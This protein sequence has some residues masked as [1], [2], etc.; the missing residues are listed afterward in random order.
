[1]KNINNFISA[2]M[3]NESVSDNDI[4]KV[5]DWIKK[6]DNRYLVEKSKDAIK[7]VYNQE[8][9]SS[10]TK[11]GKFYA[12][13]SIIIKQ[14]GDT[15]RISRPTNSGR[16]SYPSKKSKVKLTNIDDVIETLDMFAGWFDYLSVNGHE[17]DWHLPHS[18]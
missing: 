3:I 8:H 13:S 17:N 11:Y 16:A 7:I 2:S 10:N 4:E 18:H 6:Y 14:D 15:F 5:N 12:N 9:P 1:M